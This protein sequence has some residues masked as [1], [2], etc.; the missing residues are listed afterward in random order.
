MKRSVVKSLVKDCI[1]EII[2]ETEDI[3]KPISTNEIKY[4]NDELCPLG[5]LISRNPDKE[6]GTDETLTNTK[7]MLLVNMLTWRMKTY[8]M[9][10][11]RIIPIAFMTIFPEVG[12][13]NFDSTPEFNRY[14]FTVELKKYDKKT[15]WP[16]HQVRG[17]F[18]EYPRSFN[19]LV[20]QLVNIAENIKNYLVGEGVQVFPCTEKDKIEAL[21]KSGIY[22]TITT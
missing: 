10:K 6:R 4:I 7:Y 2:N 9:D 14:V 15:G 13:A 17:S 8:R 12:D 11:P 19:D 16:V 18:S 22:E 20:K 3:V 21:R 5:S 1:T